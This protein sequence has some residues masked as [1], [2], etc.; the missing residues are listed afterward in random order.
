LLAATP[1]ECKPAGTSNS[2]MDSKD[3]VFS[4]S[5]KTKLEGAMSKVIPDSVSAEMHR[6]QAAPKEKKTA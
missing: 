5:V 6:K 3:H 2:L 4:E 1:A